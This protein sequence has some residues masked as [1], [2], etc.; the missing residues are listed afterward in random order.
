MAKSSYVDPRVIDLY[1]DGTTI[2]ATVAR[3]H[4]SAEDRQTALERAVLRMLSQSAESGSRS[5]RTRS[6][7]R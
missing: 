1:E 5:A 6:P 3:S 7:A 4:K 2:A